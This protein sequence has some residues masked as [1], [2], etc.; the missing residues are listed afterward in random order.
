MRWIGEA[1]A[2]EG[3]V[4]VSDYLLWMT[5]VIGGVRSLR[6]FFGSAGCHYLSPSLLFNSMSVSSLEQ[7][8]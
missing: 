7:N 1:E 2:R 3:L 4:G 5:I 6:A 8:R